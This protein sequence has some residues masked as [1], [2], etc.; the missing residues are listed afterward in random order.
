MDPFNYSNF[1][2][3]LFFQY[4]R[5]FK[6]IS[7]LDSRFS[8]LPVLDQWF[9]KNKKI[10]KTELQTMIKTLRRHLRFKHALNVSLTCYKILLFFHFLLILSNLGCCNFDME[11]RQ[12]HENFT[13]FLV[14]GARNR[15]NEHLFNL[16]DIQN[17]IF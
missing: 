6:R 9:R 2:A 15:S 4:Q 8:I 10:E 17:L 13:L 1:Q 12:L 7:P 16:N 14:I 3:F 5:L 11:C